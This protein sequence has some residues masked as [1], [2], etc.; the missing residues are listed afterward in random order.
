MAGFGHRLARGLAPM[1]RGRGFVKRI[2]RHRPEH[3]ELDGQRLLERGAAFWF[4]DV[5]CERRPRQI[6][7]GA[8]GLGRG[9]LRLGAAD[10]GDAAFAACDALGRLVQI[11]DRALAADRAVI[12]MRGIDAEALRQLF[13][14]VAIAPAQEIDDVE[15][16]DFAEQLAAGVLLRALERLLQ[17]RQRLKAGGDLLRAIDDF[18]DADNDGDTVFGDGGG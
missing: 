11:A 10:R 4:L 8:L 18:A 3:A 13:L 7:A 15:R 14:R 9:R 17:Q 6:D 1:C 12:K 5:M 2:N 16:L